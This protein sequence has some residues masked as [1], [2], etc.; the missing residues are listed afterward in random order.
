MRVPVG[1]GFEKAG[2]RPARMLDGWPHVH[3]RPGPAGVCCTHWP[4]VIKGRVHPAR[5]QSAPVT[6]L[7]VRLFLLFEPLEGVFDVRTRNVTLLKG[8]PDFPFRLVGK[9]GAEILARI[10]G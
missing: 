4:D 10:D 9:D 8:S 7:P 1:A 3:K 2:R 6:A 5:R